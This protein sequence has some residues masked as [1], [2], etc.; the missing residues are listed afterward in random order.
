MLKMGSKYQHSVILI[1]KERGK[2]HAKNLSVVAKRRFRGVRRILDK[3]PEEVNAVS[4]DK[5]KEIRDSRSL[6]VAIKSGHL[7][8]AKLLIDRG[9][10][11]NFIEEPTS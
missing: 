7:D 6:Q 1:Y 8:I 9:A 5:P 2:G 11:L 3:K 10:D 4:G